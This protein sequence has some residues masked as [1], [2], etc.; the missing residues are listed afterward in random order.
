M[1]KLRSNY[2]SRLIYEKCYRSYEGRKAFLGTIHL[3]NPKN[4]RDSVR[5]LAYDTPK[6][7]ISTLCVTVV[8]RSYDNLQIILRWVAR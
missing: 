4:V 6:K 2:D 5:K 7:N 8:S 1:P 3:Q